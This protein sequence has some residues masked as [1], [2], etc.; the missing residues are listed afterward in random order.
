VHGLLARGAAVLDDLFDGV[1][2][3]LLAAGALTCDA[4][5]DLHWYI[6]GR[7]LLP[8]PSGLIGLA[9]S[10]PLLEHVVRTSVAEL[11]NV[12]LIGSA[13]VTGLIATPGRERVTGVRLALDGGAGTVVQDADLVVD[14]GGRGSRAPAW[15]TDLGAPAIPEDTVDVD[16]L[17]VSRR[18]RR[19]PQFLGGRLGGTSERF[20]GHPRGGFVLAQENDT[21]IVS[22]Q[23][24]A[25]VHPPIDD[26]GILEWAR[27]L[28]NPDIAEA[29]VSAEPIDEAVQMRYPQETWR[30]Y[31]TVDGLP[32][33]L[34]VIGDA[35]CSLNPLY[36]QGI[37]VAALEALL[38]RDL[39]SASVE[40]LSARYFAEVGTVIE[41]PWLLATSNDRLFLPGAQKP[42][43]ADYLARLAA[44][45]AD[46]PLV[47]RTFFRVMNLVE[48]ISRL[49]EPEISARVLTDG[50]SAIR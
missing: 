8:A 43:N 34:L 44:R 28:P 29:V 1:T 3:R 14:A 19:P 26:A 25:G 10:R 49:F 35:L 30:R 4:Q 12:K 16:L 5:R 48:P 24:G 7:L 39:L 33:G 6:D 38:L 17:Y 36:A 31:E 2:D 42:D 18:Y 27:S 46:D 50:A 47:A 15:L 23:G 21:L 41:E 13:V 9:C 32:A 22:L 40:N 11:P 45:T 20:P 37:T